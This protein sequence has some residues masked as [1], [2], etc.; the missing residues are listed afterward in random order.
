MN[1][2]LHSEAELQNGENAHFDSK[3][4]KHERDDEL[5]N[6]D[7]HSDFKVE[8]P[9]METRKEIKLSNYV[10]RHHPIEKI[11]GDKEARPM[12]RNRLRSKSCL[13]S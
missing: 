7:V 11:I 4:S 10:R 8:R 3:I 5:S 13:L 6:G 9:S 1:V 12:T 2:E